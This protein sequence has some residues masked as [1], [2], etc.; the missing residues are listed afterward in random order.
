MNTP[1]ALILVQEHRAIERLAHE[2][3]TSV[4]KVQQ[5]FLS[6]YVRLSS[7]AHVRSFLP[8]LVVNRVRAILHGRRAVPDGM[9]VPGQ[10][11]LRGKSSTSN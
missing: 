8:L 6:E 10:I 7:D 3:H 2:T 1:D 5:V 4:V 11:A 9:P